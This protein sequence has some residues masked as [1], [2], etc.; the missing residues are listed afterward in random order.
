MLTRLVT[1]I[2]T[3]TRVVVFIAVALLAGGIGGVWAATNTGAPHVSVTTVAGEKSGQ[4]AADGASNTKATKIKA[5]GNQG[6]HGACVSA[7]ARRDA[8]GGKNDNHGGAV[9]RAAHTCKSNGVGSGVG[10]SVK[11]PNGPKPTKPT[12]PT[13][14][15]T[16]QGGEPSDAGKSSR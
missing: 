11:Q 16:V 12:K 4:A 9:S 5:A 8:K 7:V 3:R 14:T 10:R 15:A 6:A 1:E 13:P 2:A